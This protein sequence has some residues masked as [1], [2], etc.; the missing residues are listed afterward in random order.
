LA[1]KCH[2]ARPAISGDEYIAEDKH[3]SSATRR[4]NIF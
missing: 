4:L 1:P 2:T 3:T